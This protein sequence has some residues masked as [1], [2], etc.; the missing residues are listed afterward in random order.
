ML[1]KV[2]LYNAVFLYEMCAIVPIHEG[3][4]GC[5][6]TRVCALPPKIIHNLPLEFSVESSIVKVWLVLLCVT[7]VD[8]DVRT[9]DTALTPLLV[10]ASY[11]RK[12]AVLWLLQDGRDR[13]NPDATNSAGKNAV[14][15]ACLD[16]QCQY[17]IEV[18]QN[19]V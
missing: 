12:N 8:F 7:A 3:K 14:H 9:R 2:S 19:I 10:A 1:R 4:S 13:I 17:T 11:N 18:S 6:G 15:L 16:L 5:F